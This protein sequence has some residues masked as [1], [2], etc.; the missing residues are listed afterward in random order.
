MNFCNSNMVREVVLQHQ[1]NGKDPCN[2]NMAKG[3]PIL[4]FALSTWQKEFLQLQHGEMS[5]FATST[6]LEEPLQ[7]QLGKTRTH[8]EL[9]I[10]NMVRSSFAPSTWWEDDLFWTSHN[11]HGEDKFCILNMVREVLH[12]Q[13][14]ER[15]TYSELCTLNMAKR[16][17]A[18]S[19]WR[20][21]F[22]YAH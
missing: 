7:I 15:M 12:H 4:D 8:S 5:C 20:E 19:T 9:C 2:F 1:H 21:N 14:G 22:S 16:S 3:G 18:P 6:R 17:F 11:Q 13:H 10:L